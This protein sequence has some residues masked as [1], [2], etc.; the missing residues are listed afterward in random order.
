MKILCTIHIL[1]YTSYI[2]IP[3]LYFTVSKTHLGCYVKR[4]TPF[5][6]L[7]SLAAVMST[8][9]SC[10]RIPLMQSPSVA[11]LEIKLPGKLLKSII[12]LYITRE[13]LLGGYYYNVLNYIYGS[14]YCPLPSG[15]SK[16]M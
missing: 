5:K 11:W 8:R 16:E 7:L 9:D 1:L 4:R 6:T 2:C 3:Q 12:F 14:P 15:F 13:N 10:W